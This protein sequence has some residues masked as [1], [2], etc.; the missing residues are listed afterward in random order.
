[1]SSNPISRPYKISHSDLGRFRMT[2]LGTGKTMKPD[3][4]VTPDCNGDIGTQ[5]IVLAPGLVRL[6][7]DKVVPLSQEAILVK[8]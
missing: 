4:P 6:D 7:A 3:S 5:T 2:D 8:L 1:M